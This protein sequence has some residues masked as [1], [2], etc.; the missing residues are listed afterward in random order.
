LVFV[1]ECRE[2][3]NSLL[4]AAPVA[5]RSVNDSIALGAPSLLPAR[6]GFTPMSSFNSVRR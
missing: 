3:W 2:C 4:A 1:G 6:V 5:R